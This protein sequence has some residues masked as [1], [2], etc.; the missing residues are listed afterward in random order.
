MRRRS[1]S[2]VKENDACPLI[3]L[4]DEKV[5]RREGLIP[6]AF[7]PG[8]PHGRLALN[9]RSSREPHPPTLPSQPPRC[10]YIKDT[11]PSDEICVPLKNVMSAAVGSPLSGGSAIVRRLFSFSPHIK[12]ISINEANFA[13]N[14]GYG[15]PHHQLL[16]FVRVQNSSWRPFFVLPPD[17]G[18]EMMV[19]RRK[20]PNPA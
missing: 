10:L 9:A 16:N 12:I 7:K 3:H 8:F 14:R 13:R 19:P 5:A 20:T 15:S 2:L 17:K 1:D 6:A 11:A 18:R 4:D